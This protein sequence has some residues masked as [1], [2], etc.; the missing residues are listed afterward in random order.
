MNESYFESIFALF[1]KKH[2]FCLFWTLFGQFLGTFPF[3]PVP[4]MPWLLNWIIFWIESAEFILNWIIFWNG[5]LVK[6]YWIEY[7]MN[8]FLAKFKHWIE[9]DL[10][11]PITSGRWVYPRA[12][13]E[14]DI[15]IATAAGP[16]TAQGTLYCG[17]WTW[18]CVQIF[19]LGR[20]RFRLCNSL[21]LWRVLL[22]G[23]HFSYICVAPSTAKIRLAGS[24]YKPSWLTR[25]HLFAIQNGFL[26]LI[27]Q[28]FLNSEIA[29]K[30]T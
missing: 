20:G 3:W 29:Q 23:S 26:K 16:P 28:H 18:C 9:S 14:S 24:E 17:G 7:W 12:V 8:R 15:P 1:D 4:M 2:P 22:L 30:S 6:Q 25:Q 27:S 10:V 11:S 13:G 21:V 5:S 19:F